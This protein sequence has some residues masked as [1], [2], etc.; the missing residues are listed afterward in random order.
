MLRSLIPGLGLNRHIKDRV[1]YCIYKIMY[2]KINAVYIYMYYTIIHINHAYTY[3]FMAYIYTHI[4]RIHHI[5]Y[6]YTAL[7]YEY[8]MLYIPALSIPGAN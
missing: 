1:Q 2:G 6:I 7:V 4:Y 5:L 8:S 3:V